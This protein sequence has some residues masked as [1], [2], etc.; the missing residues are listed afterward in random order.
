MTLV[1]P[2]HVRTLPGCKT[3]RQ[4][5]KRISELLQYGLLRAS[6]IPPRPVRELRDLPRRRTHLQSD[7]NRV[8][9]RI[10][11]LLETANLK[12]GSVVSDIAG[13]TGTLILEHITRG[14]SN[15]EELVEFA[16]GS[17]KNKKAELAQSLNGFCSEHLRWLLKEA[18]EEL[19]HLDRKLLDADQRIGEQVKPH[20]DLIR[21]LCSIP[22]VEFTTATTILAEIGL[23]MS[24][25]P[26]PAHL[27]SWAGCAPA[28][29]RAVESGSRDG[30][31]KRTDI[32]AAF[33][34]R[35]PGQSSI[36]KIVSWPRCSIASLPDA[37]GRRRRWRLVIG[38]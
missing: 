10:N 27:A 1:N 29:T 20:V 7:R 28:I 35:V 19:R 8:L 31:G 3:D 6:F 30:L 9:N 12:L 14:R 23:D 38:Y 2:Q 34:Y 21:R 11:R 36:R 5:A 4:D 26:D 32:C 16:Q 17:L 18:V 13:K 33:W 15:P 24:R 37:A 25:F 22:G